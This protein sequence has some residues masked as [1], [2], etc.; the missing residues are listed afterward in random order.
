[1]SPVTTTLVPHD[2]TLASPT[3]WLVIATSQSPCLVFRGLRAGDL[4][5][6]DKPAS[7]VKL[8][9]TRN[10]F[11]GLCGARRLTMPP[12]V[13][14]GDMPATDVRMRVEH[15]D[16]WKPLWRTIGSPRVGLSTCP[17]LARRLTG[18]SWAT[19]LYNAVKLMG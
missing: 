16:R 1:M 17:R 19:V 15:W 9:C 6:Q 3:S 2:T 4:S 11:S 14:C 8:P 5:L 13:R 10:L 18:Q 7:A 12:I